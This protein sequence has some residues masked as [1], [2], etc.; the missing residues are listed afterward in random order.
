MLQKLKYLLQIYLV[1]LKKGVRECKIKLNDLHFA[2][3]MN[4]ILLA[5][6]PLLLDRMEESW[7]TCQTDNTASYCLN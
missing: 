5:R 6:H 7:R 4:V 3:A 1:G 2:M